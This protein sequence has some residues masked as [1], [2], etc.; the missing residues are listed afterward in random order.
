MPQQK[1]SDIC[2]VNI[3]FKPTKFNP[4]IIEKKNVAYTK[5][6]QINSHHATNTIDAT[7]CNSKNFLTNKQPYYINSHTR[8]K[9]KTPTLQLYQIQRTNKKCD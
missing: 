1:K 5:A 7:T 8:N 6:Y 9:N 4:A 3:W 2:I